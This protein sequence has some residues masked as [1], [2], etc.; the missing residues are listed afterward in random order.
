[1]EKNSTELNEFSQSDCP[2][3]AGELI[4]QSGVYE[5]CHSDEP[6]AETVLVMNGVFPFCRRCGESV[7]YRLVQAVPHISEDPDFNEFF[8]ESEIPRDDAPISKQVLP[9]QLGLAHGF[10]FRHGNAPAWVNSSEAGEI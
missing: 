9:L 1:M 3:S 2:Y 10:R 8:S 4:L 5:I 6:R 7:R